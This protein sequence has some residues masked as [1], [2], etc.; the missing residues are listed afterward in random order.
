MSLIKETEKYLDSVIRSCGYG[1]FDCKL[2]TS[3]QRNL[4]QFQI[5]V[6]MPLA[7]IYHKNP[8]DIAQEI[9]DKL[10]FDPVKIII[11]PNMMEYEYGEIDEDMQIAQLI[12][13]Y[14]DTNISYRMSASYYEELSGTDLEDDITDKYNFK[15][16][17]LKAEITEYELPE[18][19]KKRYSAIFEYQGVY[20]QL[21]GSID[22]TDFEEILKKLH[23]PS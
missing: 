5:N 6:A 22:K 8:R 21:I 20:Y 10:D 18:S 16:G 14:G 2:L 13:K 9:K 12:Y 3:S 19:K 11:L 23:F 4:G 15:E 1:D 7:G 17:K